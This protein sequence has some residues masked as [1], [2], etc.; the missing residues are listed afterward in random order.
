MVKLNDFQNTIGG[1]VRLMVG[2]P[3]GV[4]YGYVADGLFGTEEEVASHAIQQ[5]KG[6]GRIR[7]RDITGDGKI[8]ED[9]QCI[10]GDPNPDLSMGLNLDFAYKG[11]TLSMFFT[12]ELG[13]DIINRTKSQLLFM[14]YGGSSTNRGRDILNAWTPENTAT[15]IP[16]VSVTDDNNETRMSTFYVEDGSYLKMKYIKL[17]YDFPQKWVKAMHATNLNVY[18]Q[19]ENIFT[20]TGYTGLD[21][22]LPLGGY[23]ARVDN[24]PYPRSRNFTMGLSMS[25]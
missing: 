6:L 15:D 23:G 3:M 13:F 8:T 11:L 25:F 2:Q 21:P 4:Y 9:D 24:A 12:S 1:D 14:S 19:A 17:S 7:Y 22:E 20:I 5:G 16:A 10:I 18:F